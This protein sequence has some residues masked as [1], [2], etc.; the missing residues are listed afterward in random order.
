MQNQGKISPKRGL[1]VDR[2]DDSQKLV[3]ITGE[4]VQLYF[5]NS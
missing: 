5:Y 1:P 3:S 4:T 2:V